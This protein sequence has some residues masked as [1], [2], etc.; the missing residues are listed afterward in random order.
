MSKADHPDRRLPE[1]R[2]SSRVRKAVCQKCGACE[3]KPSLNG[4][5]EL[6]CMPPWV[7]RCVNGVFVKEFSR[8]TRTRV[9]RRANV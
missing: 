1:A 4:V 2:V 5:C 3:T 6:K 8:G 7:G 9:D